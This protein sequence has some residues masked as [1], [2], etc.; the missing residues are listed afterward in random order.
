MDTTFYILVN[1]RTRDHLEPF[2]RFFVGNDR[3]AARELFQELKGYSKVTDKDVL[4][5]ELMERVDGLPV[6]INLKSCSLAQLSENVRL[7][8]KHVFR[9]QVHKG[10]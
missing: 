9:Q 2:G 5:I 8:T 4:C 7:I 6:N 3:L 10:P 1:I